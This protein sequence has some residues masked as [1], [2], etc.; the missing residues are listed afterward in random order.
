MANIRI[1]SAFQLS[2]T[3]PDDL[4]K[5]N[6]R[7]RLLNSTSLEPEGFGVFLT[8]SEERD[9]GSFPWVRIILCCANLLN[10]LLGFGD[11]IRG[12]GFQQSMVLNRVCTRCHVNVSD[13]KQ[14]H[15]KY[16]EAVRSCSKSNERSHLGSGVNE[17]FEQDTLRQ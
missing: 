2:Q 13:D 12:W 3:L 1:E 8:M 11:H 9:L 5:P 15:N 7:S 17:V 10:R 14:H 16:D 6:L 4:W